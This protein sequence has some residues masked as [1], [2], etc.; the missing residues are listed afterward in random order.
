MSYLEG[1]GLGVLVYQLLNVCAIFAVRDFI[2]YHLRVL[3]I[4][5]VYLL[6]SDHGN[7]KKGKQR[8]EERDKILAPYVLFFSVILFCVDWKVLVLHSISFAI[9]VRDHRQLYFSIVFVFCST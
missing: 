2:L 3:D 6:G 9:D 8:H 4:L 5:S 7:I 1:R